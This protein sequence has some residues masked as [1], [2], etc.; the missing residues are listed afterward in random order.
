MTNDRAIFVD[1]WGWVALGNR[2]DDY[3]PEV[4][5]L[6]EGLTSAKIPIHTSD[7]VLDEVITLL[8][9]REAFQNAFRF[10]QGIFQASELGQLQLHRVT[11]EDFQAAWQ[12]RQRFQD[13]PSISFTDLTSMTIMRRSKLQRVL[14]QD[15]H[16]VQVGLGFL[17]VL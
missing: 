14:T 9:K 15:E 11:T 1:T 17:R 7:Y 8:F 2:H 3:H 6:Y 13:K 12:L 16:F 10:V 4:R 5:Q